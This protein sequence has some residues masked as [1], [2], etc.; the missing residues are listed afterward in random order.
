MRGLPPPSS[1][2]C[3]PGPSRLLVIMRTDSQPIMNA[4]R[5]NLDKSLSQSI[6][7]SSPYQNHSSLLNSIPS[8]DVPAAG[9]KKRWSLFRGLAMFGTTPGS[10]RPGEVT[11]PGSPEENGSLSSGDN[12][13][14]PNSAITASVPAPR[15]STPPHQAFSFRFSLEYCP[16]RE[17]K[18]R[19]L[20]A[21][22]LP[23]NAQSILKA[24]LSSDSSESGDS[25]TSGSAASGS[26]TS[27]GSDVKTT[28]RS[29]EVKP[30]KPKD[31][32]RSLAQNSG[33]ALAEWAQV[34]NE[35]RTFY[36]RRKHEGVPRDSLVEIPTLAVENV[37]MIS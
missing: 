15:P 26:A 6:S 28:A 12:C 11:P 18:N 37:R 19:V 3:C 17:H 14:G 7:Q 2:P 16:P 8:A 21:P 33:R 13:P 24:R 34:L 9:S 32:E 5:T 22:Q 10:G 30:L 4:S 29:N 36:G 25:A 27:A 23:F 1:A 20:I 35:C 31:H